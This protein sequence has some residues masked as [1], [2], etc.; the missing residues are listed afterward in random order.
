[1]DV[2]P[3]QVKNVDSNDHQRVINQQMGEQILDLSRRIDA[4]TKVIADLLHKNE[5]S[6]YKQKTFNEINHPT[7]VEVKPFVEQNELPKETNDSSKD[8]MQRS[9]EENV[10]FNENNT[11]LTEN[12]ESKIK[13][14]DSLKRENMQ[15]AEEVKRTKLLRNC[16][17]GKHVLFLSSHPHPLIFF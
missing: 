7:R 9:V 15:L 17:I 14:N 5:P 3:V 10:L 6:N 12:L 13:E 16:A 1:M 4:L 11:S 8:E 2:F